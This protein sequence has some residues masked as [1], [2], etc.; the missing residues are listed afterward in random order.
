M[1]LLHRAI[2]RAISI[3]VGRYSEARE[4]T[5]RA[6]DRISSIALAS[7][8]VESLL[9]GLLNAFLETTASVDTVALSLREGDALRVRA[10]VGYPAPG[11]GGHEVPPSGFST[12]VE[13]EGALLLRDAS[14]NPAIAQSP[15][16]APGTRAMYGIPL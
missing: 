2:D 1:P 15:T 8:G 11:P 6:L 12:R 14:S 3:S 13:R 5:L 10:A 9:P 4:R 7:H 16:C